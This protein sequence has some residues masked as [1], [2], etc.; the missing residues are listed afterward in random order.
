MAFCSPIFL[1]T[2]YGQFIELDEC[3]YE[4]VGPEMGKLVSHTVDA[5]DHTNVGEYTWKYDVDGVSGG[6]NHRTWL[7]PELAVSYMDIHNNSVLVTGADYTDIY[8]A[9]SKGELRIWQVDGGLQ[10]RLAIDGVLVWDLGWDYV[11]YGWRK[12]NAVALRLAK[13]QVVSAQFYNSASEQVIE[14]TFSPDVYTPS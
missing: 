4:R 3:L 8:T 1:V 14:C 11:F 10:W 7:A 5:N 2:D 9:P 12:P 6:N 13:D